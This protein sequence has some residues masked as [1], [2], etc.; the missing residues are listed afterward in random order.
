MSNTRDEMPDQGDHRSREHE[1]ASRDVRL[2]ALSALAQSQLQDQDVSASQPSFAA[3]HEIGDLG[4]RSGGKGRRGPGKRV[5]LAA[6]CLLAVV[7]IGARV[8]PM[9]T[10]SKNTQPHSAPIVSIPLGADGLKCPQNLTWSPDSAQIAIIGYAY[11]CPNDNPSTHQAYP[12]IIN[13]YNVR[14]LRLV[15]QLH[16]DN[17]IVHALN[18]TPTPN[19]ASPAAT[20]SVTSPIIQYTDIVWSH[21]GH[22]L[23]PIFDI[24]EWISAASTE[25]M[26]GVLLTD[27]TGARASAYATKSAADGVSAGE[28]DVE[29]GGFHL[30]PAPSD[31]QFSSISPAS[32]YQWRPDGTLAPASTPSSGASASPA[33][34]GRL[35]PIG[36]PD[37]SESFMVWQP[38][39]V[40]LLFGDG[41]NNSVAQ[42]PGGYAWFARFVAWSPDGRYITTP[43]TINAP[44]ALPGV[45]LPSQQALKD[46][47]F[48]RAPFVPAHD[49]ALEAAFHLLNQS[50][51]SE[52]RIHISWRPDG[53]ILAEYVTSGQRNDTSKR[54]VT[55]Y[56]AVTGK[57]LGTLTPQGFVE[58]PAADVSLLWSPDG[59]RLL[60]FDPTL[61]AITIWG[62]SQLPR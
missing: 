2:R 19:E 15:A 36:S 27:E 28:W 7:G 55:L 38:G 58:G 30:L 5:I 23:A 56:D 54:V 41:G 49:K 22:R 12:G 11:D 43:I 48:D 1:A 39:Q 42:V 32:T 16:P 21:D 3:R 18:I 29:T 24:S 45:P 4:I 25:R 10:S 9:L 17:A 57:Q 53:R 6:L 33:A 8:L 46:A 26:Q 34:T 37:Q 13:I 40:E 60:L 51:G 52:A 44:V 20:A 14:S 61:S 47:H 31:D 50:T 59:S 35:G 62:P